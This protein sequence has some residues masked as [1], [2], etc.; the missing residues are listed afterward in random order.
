MPREL[1]SVALLAGNVLVR[2]DGVDAR[3]AARS[4]DVYALHAGGGMWAADG[5]AE[6]HAGGEKVA[7][8]SELAGHLGDGV[9]APDGLAD[10]SELELAARGRA[11][12]LFE[13]CRIPRAIRA[14][15]D[16]R[17]K[18]G[19]GKGWPLVMSRPPA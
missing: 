13:I 7:R 10:A 4:G 16:A 14:L 11:H 17:L 2:E 9:D 15:L 12:A 18:V 3:H 6:Q 5:V 19:G 8:V 1:E